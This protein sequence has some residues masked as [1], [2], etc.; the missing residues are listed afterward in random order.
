MNSARRDL[1]AL[2]ALEKTS[3]DAALLSTPPAEITDEQLDTAI[4]L[5][6]RQRP[7]WRDD[8]ERG[9]ARG[10]S[11]ERRRGRRDVTAVQQVNLPGGSWPSN[12]FAARKGLENYKQGL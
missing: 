7:G 3:G 12:P 4:V 9:R 11:L 10:T 5:I 8:I 1:Q 2:G 6:K